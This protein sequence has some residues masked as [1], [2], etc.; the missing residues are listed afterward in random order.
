MTNPVTGFSYVILGATIY[1]VNSS[2]GA[3]TGSTGLSCN[4][5]VLSPAYNFSIVSVTGTGVPTLPPTGTTGNVYG[6]HTAISGNLSIT[7]SGTITTTCKIN[8]TVNNSLI[9]GG[10]ANVTGSGTYSIPC[11]AAESDNVAIAIITGTC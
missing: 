11:S 5:Y 7:I 2:T 6:H 3:V 4:N 9:G 1:T 10:C 8:V